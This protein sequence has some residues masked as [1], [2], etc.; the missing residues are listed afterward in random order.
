MTATG[1]NQRT[2]P[3]ARPADEL[4]VNSSC[5]EF[6]ATSA[7]DA[8]DLPD[9]VLRV[10]VTGHRELPY[11]QP[12]VKGDTAL[13]TSVRQVLSTL[14]AGMAQLIETSGKF[15]SPQPPRIRFVSSFADGADQL[16]GKLVLEAAESDRPGSAS[17]VVLDLAGVLPFELTAYREQTIQ[18][19]ATFHRLLGRASEVIELDGWAEPKESTRF[20]QS[21]SA[22]TRRRQQGFKA[23]LW[24]VLQNVD[25]LLAI[26]NPE[27]EGKP[28]G[29]GESVEQALQ[30]GIPILWINPVDPG[31]IHFVR[32]MEDFRSS[33]NR[34]GLWQ[35]KLHRCING[36]LRFPTTTRIHEHAPHPDLLLHELTAK[37][38]VPSSLRGMLYS[39][40]RNALAHGR[41]E[42]D[43]RSA[44]PRTKPFST[45]RATASSLAGYYAG[46]YRG[47]FLLN[48]LLSFLTI[49]L[50]GVHLESPL[51]AAIKTGT[52]LG[53]ICLIIL[54]TRQARKADWQSRSIDYRFLAE[55]LRAMDF[56]A[57]LGISTPG[58]QLPAQWAAHDPRKSWMKWLFAALV[59]QSPMAS[60]PPGNNNAAPQVKRLC[61]AHVQTALRSIQDEWIKP[62]RVHHRNNA[63]RMGRLFERIE[64]FGRWA[65]VG[66]LLAVLAALVMESYNA[67]AGGH[68]GHGWLFSLSVLAVGLP[69]LVVS[70]N[71]FRFQAECRRLRERSKAMSAQL[72]QA[73]RE[74]TRLLRDDDAQ[75]GKA[76]DAARAGHTLAQ[77]MI[78]E[79]ADWRVHYQMHEVSAA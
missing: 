62:Q 4:R 5:G 24:F 31:F 46:L 9:L 39:A 40:F 47:A 79:V 25:V 15:Y 76:W 42:P 52:E 71:G 2:A 74:F 30:L 78:N 63:R 23:A 1:L 18:D 17:R 27:Q 67:V 13:T 72:G 28:G 59:R 54:N 22:S 73:N 48:Y 33:A 65:F 57:P 32:R 38:S 66:A 29:T 35:E 70:L 44:S 34:E 49:L 8:N 50:A 77:L 53:F 6:E 16:V 12:A 7:R 3:R 11:G 58:T 26:W 60:V 43:S 10:G 41:I 55:M 51:G 69:A 19:K 20:T 36:L 21:L 64:W 14:A 45:W 56:L 75:S 61:A 68:G 37:N